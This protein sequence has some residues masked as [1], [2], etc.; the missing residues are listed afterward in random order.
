M[1]L[2]CRSRY[3]PRSA[4]TASMPVLCNQGGVAGEGGAAHVAHFAVVEATGTVHRRAI[5]PHHEVEWPPG[6]RVDELA[7]R[8]VLGQV[9]QEHAC[10]GDC[11]AD[12][13][14][15]MGGEKQRLPAGCR[16]GSH[17]RLAHWSEVLDLL[18]RHIRKADRLTGI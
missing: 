2:I 13:R 15:R 6:M 18:G 10:F 17:E 12:D 5:V 14:P 7:L 3:S 1:L 8:R 4:S 11:P 9:A 16:V